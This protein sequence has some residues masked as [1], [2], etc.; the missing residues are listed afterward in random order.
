MRGL[1]WLHVRQERFESCVTVPRAHHREV[2]IG[3]TTNG[4]FAAEEVSA[5]KTN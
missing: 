3:F 1:K 2:V 4:S 5:A